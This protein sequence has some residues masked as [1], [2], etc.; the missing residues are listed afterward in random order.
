MAVSVGRRDLLLGLGFAVV[1]QAELALTDGLAT[2]ARLASS[3][4]A[5]ATLGFAMRRRHPLAVVCVLMAALLGQVAADGVLVSD[6]A[7]PLVAVC[8]ACYALGRHANPTWRVATGVAVAVGGL[9]AANQLEPDLTYSALDDLVFFALFATATAVFGRLLGRR[10]ELVAELRERTT[11]LRAARAEEAAAAAAEERARLAVGLHDALAHRIA[12]I[13]LQA[14]GAERVAARDP[15]RSREALARIESGARAALDDIRSLIGA[16]RRGEE[17]IAL[18]PHD[19]R[20][21]LASIQAPCRALEPPTTRTRERERDPLQPGPLAGRADVLLAA[22]V[23]LAIVVETLTSSRLSGPAAANVLGVAV[24]TAPLAWRRR[25][26]LAAAITLFAAA[27]VHSVLLTPFGL[28]VTPLVLLIVPAYSLAAHLPFRP[29][30]AGLL[31]CVAGSLAVEPGVATGVLGLGAWGAG[32][33]VRDQS[34]RVLELR[35]LATEIERARNAHHDRVREE[36]RLRIA[37][38]LHDAVAHSMTVI[39]LQAGAAQRV[40]TTD[41]EAAGTAVQALSRVAREILGQLREALRG[42]DDGVPALECLA[43]LEGLAARMR[44]LGLDV[45]LVREGPVTELPAHVDHVGF[46]VVQEALTNAA[47]YAAPT[48]VNIRVRHSAGALRI[49]VV[50][51]G[52]PAGAHPAPGDVGGTGSGLHGMAERV[53]ACRGELRYGAAGGGFGVHVS[54]PVG[55]PA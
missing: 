22:A 40:W 37:R 53:A 6:L 52:R 50:D 42:L 11:A 44:P 14:A 20:E 36:E 32:R 29:A 3:A 19:A 16:L 48:A 15:A 12:A 38:E 2:G 45:S 35:D 39:V 43:A 24:V 55:N 34:R 23:G 5:L 1:L 51:A 27:A 17:R 41:A 21:P 54:L 30:L 46:R 33:A 8:F 13:S 28:L 31:V 47:R 4:A 49:D 7:T 26:P 25:R 9:T 18:M 10:A